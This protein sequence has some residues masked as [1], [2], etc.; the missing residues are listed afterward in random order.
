MTVTSQPVG[1][2]KAWLS[3][4]LGDLRF[5]QWGKGLFLVFLSGTAIFGGLD[6]V[7][8]A[9]T[10]VNPGESYN[11]GA[12]EVT[13]KRA[14]VVPTLTAGDRVLGGSRPGSRYL[15]VVATVANDSAYDVPLTEELDL[16]GVADAER[17]GVF[18]VAD[19]SRTARLGPGLSDEMAFVW[20]IPDNSLQ[21]G[22]TA[23]VRIWDKKYTELVVSYGKAWIDSLTDYGQ[24][25]VPVEL[26]T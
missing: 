8:T 5:T 11:D 18:R 9:V 24:V 19:G 6:R 7:E 22:D 12:L 3:N 16:R 1:R 10:T 4:W 14:T 21:T 17:F 15:A 2:R 13:V 26:R 23:A 25:D 20:K